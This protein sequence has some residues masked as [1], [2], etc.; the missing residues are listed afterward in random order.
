MSKDSLGDPRRH[1]IDAPM[2]RRRLFGVGAGAV[3]AAILTGAPV[4]AGFGRVVM[5]QDGGTEFHAAYPYQAPPTGHFNNFVTNAI[6][7]SGT[8][9]ALYSEMIFQPLGMYYWAS[10]EWLPLLATEWSF[11]EDGETFEIK[12]REGVVWSDETPFTANDYEATLQCYRIMSGTLWSYIDEVNVVD[13]LTV[14]LHMSTPSTVVER[15]AIR[16]SNPQPASIYGEWADRARE[17]FGGGGT[18]D[19]PEGKQLLDQFNQFRPEN[20]PVTGP[21]MIDVNSITSAQMTL[22]KNDLAWNVD[23]VLFDRIVNYNGE[24]DTITPLVLAEEIDYATH[25]FSP[26]SEQQFLDQGLRILR[27]PV[28][29]GPALYINFN[30]HGETLGDPLVR[31]AIAHAVDRAQNGQIS[32]AESGVAVQYMTGMSDNLVPQWV[33]P[34]A[35]ETFDQYPYDQEQ[36]TALLEEAGWTKDGDVWTMANGEEARFELSFPA[37][38]AD[39]SA[40]GSDAAEQL[41]NFGIVCEPRAVTFT[42]HEIDVNQGNFD[43]AIRAWGASS[44]PHPHFSYR[45]D[46]LVHNTLAINDGGEGMGFDLVQDTEVAGEVDLEVLVRDSALGLDEEAQIEHI[47]TIAQVFNELLPIIPLFERYGNN[48]SLEGVRVAAWPADDDPILKN[49][50]YADGIPT[51]LM[52]TGDLEPATGS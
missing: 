26:A 50:P 40:S 11:L 3:G 51:M 23:N 18:I 43:I 39:W 7:P 36:A 22:V 25:G 13:D 1:A 47:T 35:V 38:F 9:P 34:D 2:S 28:Y 29:S 41:T 21:F 4:P 48:A 12:L 45:Q 16:L 52:Y 32:L 6:L 37:E 17:F 20:I 49:S 27:P 33:T 19:D 44:S 15:Y 5:A 24:T 10:G 14:H 8:A 42:Q 30:R 46:L 31:R